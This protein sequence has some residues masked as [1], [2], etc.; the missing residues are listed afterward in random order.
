M[1]Y[2]IL[3]TILVHLT[4]DLSLPVMKAVGRLGR[5]R[6][7]LYGRTFPR[8]I[9][10]DQAVEL[11]K[12]RV[13]ESRTRGAETLRRRRDAAW[14]KGVSA[15]QWMTLGECYIVYDIGCDILW[16]VLRYRTSDWPSIS[17]TI[18]TCDIEQCLID[19]EGMKPRYRQPCSWSSISKVWNLRYRMIQVR[20]SISNTFDIDIR[21]RRFK[22]SISNEH[23]IS[24]SSIS[25]VT[26]DIE[27]PTLDIGVARIQMMISYTISE[28]Y[29][30]DIIC[31][32]GV[33]CSEFSELS[34][35]IS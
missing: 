21:Y 20:P 7:W 28:V 22:T 19:I 33:L 9:S 2:T 4:D 35:M 34:T 31:W 15:P 16:Y 3:H 30:Y 18:S 27:G 1:S 13:Q 29:D 5:R 17:Q 10:V 26:F 25:N 12:K 6:M 32:L 14:A 8:Q 24:T 23:S 11:R